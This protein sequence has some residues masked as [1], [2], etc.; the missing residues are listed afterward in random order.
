MVM[1]FVPSA[2]GGREGTEPVMPLMSPETPLPGIWMFRATSPVELEA[3]PTFRCSSNADRKSTR[4]NSS[5]L[6]ISYAVFC[7][8]KKNISE[9]APEQQ[10][11]P[12]ITHIKR[13]CRDTT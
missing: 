7:L 12:N 11:A 3:V 4:L 13:H 6:G 5:H 10:T 9:R 2:A 1:R 8:K